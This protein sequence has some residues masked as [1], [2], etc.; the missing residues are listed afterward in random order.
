MKKPTCT[1]YGGRSFFIHTSRKRKKS[2]VVSYNLI[3]YH[4][5]AKS[6][7]KQPLNKTIF[8][9]NRRRKNKLTN[10]HG[11]VIIQLRAA[12]FERIRNA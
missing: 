1:S 2:I 6:K 4:F 7:G 12:I 9:L 3:S 10:G 11:E 8:K 5:H